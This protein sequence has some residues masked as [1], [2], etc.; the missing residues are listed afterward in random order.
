M[1]KKDMNDLEEY[2]NEYGTPDRSER[3]LGIVGCAAFL[4]V[5]GLLI[6]ALLF[7]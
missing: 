7:K 6:C 2:C 5:F 3:W 1:N 4:L